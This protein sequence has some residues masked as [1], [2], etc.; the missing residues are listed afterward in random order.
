MRGTRESPVYTNLMEN[1]IEGTPVNQKQ[2]ELYRVDLSAP[3]RVDRVVKKQLSGSSVNVLIINKQN[4]TI[5]HSAPG[6]NKPRQC[7][8]GLDAGEQ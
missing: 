5:G 8:L 1:P 6:K 4:N 2:P 7:R 3:V